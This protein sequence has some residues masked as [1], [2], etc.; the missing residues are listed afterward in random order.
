MAAGIGFIKSH[1]ATI[2]ALVVA[3]VGVLA[4]GLGP[5]VRQVLT[6]LASVLGAVGVS[7]MAARSAI[8]SEARRLGL[9]P[10]D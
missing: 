1:W 8:R 5:A 2:S 6:I 7:G 10:R 9:F 3:I 4:P